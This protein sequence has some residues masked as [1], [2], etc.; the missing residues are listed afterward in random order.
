VTTVGGHDPTEVA[1]DWS[2]GDVMDAYWD[3]QL[4]GAL[5]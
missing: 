5:E 2:Y 3:L 1:R 4:K